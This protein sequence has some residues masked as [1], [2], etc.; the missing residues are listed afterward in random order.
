MDILKLTDL[1]VE[2]VR[3]LIGEAE[4]AQFRFETYIRRLLTSSGITG[5][6]KYSLSPDFSTLVKQ[7]T[8]APAAPSTSAPTDDKGN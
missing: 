4:A 6:D 5:D 2:S 8:P 3:N 7:Q 1:E